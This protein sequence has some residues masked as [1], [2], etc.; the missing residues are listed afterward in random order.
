[1]FLKLTMFPA[2]QTIAILKRGHTLSRAVTSGSVSGVHCVYSAIVFWLLFPTGQYY[3][4][5]LLACNGGVFGSL[6]RC[7]FI[8][9]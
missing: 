4:E 7:A 5:L 8:C 6:T 3:S 1:M 2:P 9:L